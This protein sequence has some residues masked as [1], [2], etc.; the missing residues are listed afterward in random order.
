MKIL[1]TGATGF[2]GSFLIEH[3]LSTIEK[4]QENSRIFGTY[5]SDT[6][7]PY[8]EFFKD[9]ISLHKL[10]LTDFAAVKKT[11]ADIAPDQIY[12]LAAFPSPAASFKDP[13]AFMH[14]NINAQLYILESLREH[15]FFQTRVVVISSS[16]VYGHVDATELPMTEKTSLNPVSPY[17]VSKIAQDFLGLQ[18]FNAY[19]M[20]I[21]RL[22][23][24]GHIGPR[25]S[26][27]F[28][29]SIFAKKVAEIEK[30]KREPILTVG[31]LNTRRDLTDVRD[32]VKAYTL[33]MEKGKPG[34]VYNIGSGV[35]HKIGD[36]LEILLSFSET[37][38]QIQEDEALKRPND[39]AELRCD[40]TKMHTLT[41]WEPQI[42]LEQSLKDMLEYWREI[43]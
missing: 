22:R 10:D 42:K 29:A 43:V 31:N 30:G 4:D 8:V 33:L 35:S 3:L 5:V 12:H 11:I 38:I 32:I 19:Q 16:E 24:F 40:Y 34:D 20:P 14:N 13:G 18:Y 37:K 41:G 26:D 36:V 17:G 25:L 9:K 1:V 15:N 21:I 7:P 23:P 6:F 28:A 27:Q 39:I 2:A